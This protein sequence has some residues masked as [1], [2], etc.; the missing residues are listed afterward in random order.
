[1]ATEPVT[2][3]RQMNAYA[4]Q[5]G[6]LLGLWSLLGLY[7]MVVSIDRP[8]W[9]GAG[10]LLLLSTP[11]AGAFFTL[12]FRSQVAGH[13]DGFS[14]G[15]GYLHTLLMGLYA[16]VW[17]ALGVYAYF[18]FMDGGA[19]VDSLE[20]W[21]LEPANAELVRQMETQGAFDDLYALSGTEDFVGAIDS[22]RH[23]PPASYAGMVISWTLLSA[24]VIS[25]FIGLLAMRRSMRL[26]GIDYK[27]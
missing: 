21:A 22:F 15:R 2:P 20:R 3:M 24:P 4:M 12:R 19:F 9:V 13:G 5:Y 14:F 23:I 8:A 25:I 18:R 6:L 27:G 11:F 1:M 7:V 16:S 10:Q 26:P 17:I